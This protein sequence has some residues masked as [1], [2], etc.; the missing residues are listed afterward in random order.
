[1][2]RV[3]AFGEVLLRLEPP[4]FERLFQSPVL[5]TTFAGAECNALVSLAGFGLPA[6]FVSAIPDNAVGDA[7]LA[8]LRRFG[9]DTRFVRRQ[10]DRL[11]VFFLETGSNQRPSKVTY[12][13]GASSLATARPGDFD[14]DGILEG[15]GWL[16][17]T[18]I[19]PALGPSAAELALEA[20]RRARAK[21][22]PVSCDYNYRG[23]L[24]RYGKSPPEVMRGLME[25][26][27]VGIAGREDCQKMLGIRAEV[28]PAPD[29]VD[30]EAYRALAE[31]VLQEFPGLEMQVITLRE[32]SSASRNRW[33]ACL[34]D[35]R[36]FLVSPGYEIDQI[37]DRVGAGDAFSGALIYGLITHGDPR[38]ALEFATAA[39][40]LAHTIPGDFNRMS[41][42][43]VDALVRGEAPGRVR[44]SPERA[45]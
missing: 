18:G 22:L 7:C 10:G 11:G 38:A 36:D 19:T 35:R 16:H 20:V 5:R 34:H 17:L 15:A 26:V 25:H 44:R 27:T 41:V 29:G 12:D 3:V 8:E 39:S 43:E 37:V 30:P 28:D 2:T 9:V 31:R 14:W 23:T 6:S 40:C 1:M 45:R 33:S 13:R 21:A 32:G 42:A 24:W 4:G